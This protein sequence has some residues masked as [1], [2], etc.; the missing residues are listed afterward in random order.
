VL[1]YADEVH[2]AQGYFRDIDDV[3]PEADL[4]DL[5]TTLIDKKSAPFKPAE[6]H[7]RYVEALE[8]LIEKKRKSKSSKLILED[9]EE[10]RPKGGNVI[11][12]MAALKKSVGSGAAAAKAES[13][14]KRPAT[15]AKT[16]KTPATPTKRRKSA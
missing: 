13:A 4:L 7:D 12:L 14:P 10:A 1:R 8:R 3:K 16:A 9:T 5:A 6:F 2:K 15:K 11:D